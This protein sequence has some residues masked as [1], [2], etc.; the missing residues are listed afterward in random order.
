VREAGAREDEGEGIVLTLL[1][2]TARSRKVFEKKPRREN[3][4]F[5]RTAD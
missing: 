2:E 5:L 4:V 3:K 1:L